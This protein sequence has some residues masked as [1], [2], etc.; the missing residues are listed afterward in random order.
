MKSAAF[1]AAEE[2]LPADHVLNTDL[3][4]LRTFIDRGS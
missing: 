4:Q 2:A 1:D 3:F